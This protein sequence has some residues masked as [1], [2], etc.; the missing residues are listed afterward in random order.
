MTVQHKKLH[1]FASRLNAVLAD[2]VLKTLLKTMKWSFRA[3][4]L[5]EGLS[6]HRFTVLHGFRDNLRSGN[7]ENWFDATYVFKTAANEILASVVFKDGSMEVVSR[8]VKDW[9]ITIVFRDCT[10]FWNFLFSGGSDILTT[11]LANDVTVVGNLNYLYKFGFMARDLV[12][13]SGADRLMIQGKRGR[14]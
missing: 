12:C 8:E 10:A 9:D 13:R 2:A 7:D 11:V 5:S 3:A 6:I 1:S 14:P 4:K